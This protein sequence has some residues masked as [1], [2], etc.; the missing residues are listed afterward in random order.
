MPL[1]ICL[2]GATGW[3]GSAL[4]R[5]IAETND[6]KLVAAVS[7]QHAGRSLGEVLEVAQL[8]DVMISGSAEEALATPCDV[9]VEYTKPEVAK[10]NVMTALA[11]GANVVIGTS[12][13]TDDDLA[14]IGASAEQQQ[15]GVLAVGNF[16]MAVTVLQK[17]AELAA[18]YLPHYEIIDYA[19]D[20]KKDVPSGT[21]RELAYRLSKVRLPETAVPLD[22]IQGPQETRGATLNGVQVHSIRLPGYTISA[23]VV[24]GDLDQKLS[25]R[26]DSGSSP[27]PYVAGALLAIRRVNSF[28]GLK[29]GLDSVMDF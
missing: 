20:Y 25:I 17:C 23:E 16:S 19:H 18:H 28:T 12:G 1:N 24:F 6:L 10:T 8:Q 22:Q 9:F 29:R 14:A 4:A 26:Y 13:L 3:A 27:E 7:R 11:H 15:K 5:A 2:A 21:A